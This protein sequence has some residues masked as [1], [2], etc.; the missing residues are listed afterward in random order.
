MPDKYFALWEDGPLGVRYWS[1]PHHTNVA[2][3]EAVPPTATSSIVTRVLG[4]MTPGE[5]LDAMAILGRQEV[6]DAAGDHRG[7]DPPGS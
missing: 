5:K 6:P 3:R 4:A 2:A 1:G 7:A